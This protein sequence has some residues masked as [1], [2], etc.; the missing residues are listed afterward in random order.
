MLRLLTFNVWGRTGPWA[1]RK[2]ILVDALEA[3]APDVVCLQEVWDGE[4]GN[5]AAELGTWNMHYAHATELAPGRVSGNAILS[6]WPVTGGTAWA[7]PRTRGDIGRNLV[8]AIVETPHGKLP[9]F[10]THLSWM[11]HHSPSRFAQEQDIAAR[12]KRHAPIAK[13]LGVLPAVL[14]GDFNAEPDADEIRYLR[15]LTANPGGV[16]FT[17]A[18]AAA[19]EGPGHTWHRANPFAARERSPNRRLDYVFV[20]G[21]DRWNRGDVASARVVLDQPVDG[22]FAS[23]HYG[24]LAEITVAPVELPPL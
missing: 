16:Y 3:L 19:G 13:D 9:V 15:G 10:T 8:H 23:D 18:F 4:G 21:P 12:I 7:L 17:D 2:A 5:L 1:Q 22:I 11:F 24:V 20:R 6:R 14:A